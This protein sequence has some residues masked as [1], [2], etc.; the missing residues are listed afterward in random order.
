MELRINPAVI[1]MD[2]S[3]IRD[4]TRVAEEAGAINLAQGFPEYP[5]APELREAA[6]EVTRELDP[7]L[8]RQEAVAQLWQEHLAGRCDHSHRLWLLWMWGLTSI[9]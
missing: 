1:H 7:H 6:E 2:E 3:I 5:I 8:F 4:M 9:S